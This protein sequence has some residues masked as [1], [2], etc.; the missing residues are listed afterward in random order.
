M[1]VGALL[2]VVAL[3][4]ACILPAGRAEQGAAQGSTVGASFLSSSGPAKR[5][6]PKQNL[7][8]PEE[9]KDCA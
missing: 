9:L 3:A 5:N 4:L 8:I 1:H 2:F 6:I 7:E